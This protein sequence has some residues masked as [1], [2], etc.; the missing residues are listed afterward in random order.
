MSIENKDFGPVWILWDKTSGSPG[1]RY[2]WIFSKEELA[3]ER[4]KI[5][6]GNSVFQS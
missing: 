3:I 1:K 2:A 5:H 4:Y 6:Q